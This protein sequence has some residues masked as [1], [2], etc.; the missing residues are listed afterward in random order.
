MK[1]VRTI[2]EKL[3]YIFKLQIT[4]IELIILTGNVIEENVPGVGNWGG[5]C[6]CPD[7]HEYQVGDKWDLCKSLACING[8]TI[9]CN[10]T[11]GPW[12]GRKVTCAVQPGKKINAC[13]HIG[14]E[15]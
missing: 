14:Y 15:S 8:Q 10:K 12:K 6:R 1:F 3:P 5:T 2:L 9:S 13:T 11:T 4:T 7:G